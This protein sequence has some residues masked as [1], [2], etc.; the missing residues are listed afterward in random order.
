MKFHRIS[1]PLTALALCA[2]LATAYYVTATP[3]FAA[4]TKKV[5]EKKA[6]DEVKDEAQTETAATGDKTAAESEEEADVAE[7][8][9]DILSDDIMPP[10]ATASKT[11]VPMDL[12]SPND[13][14]IAP[15]VKRM[16]TVDLDAVGSSDAYT[17]S[18][19][20]VPDGTP[21]VEPVGE[22]HPTLNLTPDKSIIVRLD[23]PA[24]WVSPRSP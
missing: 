10:M 5:A 13:S 23:R 1:K 18:G 21:Y 16:R 14:K 7:G 3:S 12:P 20:T 8:E 9:D 24:A 22:T 4:D 15:D 6:K 17:E 11:E 19:L 2:L